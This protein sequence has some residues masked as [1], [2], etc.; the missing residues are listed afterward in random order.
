MLAQAQQLSGYTLGEP[1]APAGL[2]T[3]ENLERDRDQ[4]D[5]LPKI[6]LGASAGSK[7]KQDFTALGVELK[8]IPV[9][10]L[11]RPLET[12]F[13]CVAPLTDNSGAT[14]EV[15]HVYHKL[16]HVLWIL[17]KSECNILLVKCRVGS[18]L[19]WSPD[20]EEDRQL[21]E[22]WEEL[23]DMIV[24]GQ[25]ERITARHGEYLQTRPKAAN[26]KASTETISAWGGQILTLSC[27]F[28][29]KKNFASALLAHHFLIQ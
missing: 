7:P 16:K 11:S 4:I 27:G 18:P 26:A 24:L 21:R 5:M 22:D 6:W 12:T 28:Y 8:I 1:A 2:A 17:A 25:T 13:I 23:I 14:W 15:S 3:S 19:L 29:L 20:E 9:D 10:S